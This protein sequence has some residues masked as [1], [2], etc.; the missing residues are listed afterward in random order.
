MPVLIIP[1][2]MLTIAEAFPNKIAEILSSG[3][4]QK[5]FRVAI[6][7]V[8]GDVGTI[9]IT[10]T[11]PDWAEVIRGLDASNGDFSSWGGHGNYCRDGQNGEGG[12]RQIRGFAK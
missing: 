9:E 12:W 1:S 6:A 7:A 8:D 2:R 5:A 11:I 3:D 4:A 10:T